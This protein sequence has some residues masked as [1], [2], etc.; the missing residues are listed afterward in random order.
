MNPTI[1]NTSSTTSSATYLA[2]LAQEQQAT[3]NYTTLPVAQAIVPP[4]SPETKSIARKTNNVIPFKSVS[5]D[6]GSGVVSQYTTQNNL[7]SIMDQN[8]PDSF[9]D[10]SLPPDIDRSRV[11]QLIIYDTKK[12]K[13]PLIQSNFIINQIRESSAESVQVVQGFEQFMVL[14]FNPQVSSITFGGMLINDS[15]Y[16][17]YNYFMNLYNSY[18]K[19]SVNALNGYT[20]Y[21]RFFNNQ[22]VEAAFVNLELSITAETYELIPM[23]F[24][25]IVLRRFFTYTEQTTGLQELIMTVDYQDIAAQLASLDPS[26]PDYQEKRVALLNKAT[27][28]INA[29]IPAKNVQIIQAT[30]SSIVV[31][32]ASP[33]DNSNIIQLPSDVEYLPTP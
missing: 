11:V 15:N 22:Y 28:D 14:F 2:Q 19:G 31:S 20:I 26:S 21:I 6:K 24:S 7:T 25:V 33:L 30:P 10:I 4:K 3:N 12:S 29:S 13:R 5:I 18:L 23:S 8:L 9:F 27:M 1:M 32:Y 17:Q 16:D